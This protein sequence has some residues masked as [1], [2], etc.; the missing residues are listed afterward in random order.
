VIPADVAAEVARRLAAGEPDPTTFGPSP[1]GDGGDLT[2]VIPVGALAAA[3][4][5]PGPAGAQGP[6]APPGSQG[7]GAPAPRARG[8][9]NVVGLVMALVGLVLAL[10]GVF[11]LPWG[12][13]GGDP[14]Y[15][16][17]RDTV[18]TFG[19]PIGALPTSLML[20]GGLFAVVA[21][22]VVALARAIGSR[23]LSVVALVVVILSFLGL[24]ALGVLAVDVDAADIPGLSDDTASSTVPTDQ[25]PGSPVTDPATGAPP[26]VPGGAPVTDP[27]TGAAPTVPDQ[28]QGS[29]DLADEA[30]AIAED[31]VEDAERNLIGGA[32]VA[33]A[34]MFLATVLVGVG[35]VRRPNGQ[36]L[37]A[38]AGLALVAGWVIVGTMRLGGTDGIGDLGKGPWV[39]AVGCVLFALSTL[40]PR[41]GGRTAG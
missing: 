16:D 14:G 37:M 27:I 31:Q 36:A 32:I 26:T 21:G 30:A 35:L 6:A 20:S 34:T 33:F 5:A 15:L 38:F 18:D 4:G 13:G 28:G 1:A 8:G 40:V 17:L 9:L 24:S 39:L 22:G 41:L 2:T 19:P 7:S 12:Q 23:A 29:E 10:V 11:L 3:P 25:L